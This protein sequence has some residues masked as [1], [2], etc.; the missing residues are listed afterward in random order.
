MTREVSAH[1]CVGGQTPACL[2][3]VAAYIRP[4]VRS[5]ELLA[6]SRIPDRIAPLT[7]IAHASLKGGRGSSR[8]PMAAIIDGS[9][10][11]KI[12]SGAVRCLVR[13]RHALC[14]ERKMAPRRVH[15]TASRIAALCEGSSRGNVLTRRKED[16]HSARNVGIFKISAIL[17]FSAAPFRKADIVSF[18][19]T[20]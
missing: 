13:R 1:S 16:G 9:A 20:S 3:C 4:P 5:K 8:K 11:R 17:F 18:C 10:S 12:L 2:P 15:K 19:A 14:V 6:C 7:A